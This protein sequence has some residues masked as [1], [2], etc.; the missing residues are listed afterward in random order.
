MGRG[1]RQE[2]LGRAGGVLAVAGVHCVCHG[3]A[4]RLPAS[5]P[6]PRTSPRTRRSPRRALP[7]QQACILY[8]MAVGLL[9]GRP[10]RNIPGTQWVIHGIRLAPA[11]QR[12]LARSEADGLASVGQHCA[13]GPASQSQHPRAGPDGRTDPL[14]HRR[15]P[16]LRA[17]GRNVHEN[18]R[19]GGTIVSSTRDRGRD[20][21]RGGPLS[22]SGQLAEVDVTSG[23]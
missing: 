1:P 22:R 15:L 17:G 13:D 7:W 9:G 4:V 16:T 2:Y 21:G 20:R 8:A 14:R 3:G 23:G 12:P 6:L 5:L 10:T 18:R 19:A 11:S